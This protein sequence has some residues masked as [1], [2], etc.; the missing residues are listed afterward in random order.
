MIGRNSDGE[1]TFNVDDR[2]EMVSALKEI[3]ATTAVGRNYKKNYYTKE[4]GDADHEKLVKAATL[5]AGSENISQSHLVRALT[6]LLDSGEIQPKDF[7]QAAPLEEPQEDTRPRDKNGKLL[8][9]SQLRYREYRQFAETAS[10]D[11]INKRKRTDPGF[12][13]YV[14]KAY[15]AEVK[16]PIGDGVVPEGQSKLPRHDVSQTLVDFARKYNAEPITNLRPKGGFV[17]LAGE[18]IRWSDF[19]SLLTKATEAHLI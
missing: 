19:Q 8:N 5:V 18:Q 14:R 3:F 13:S 15:E 10:M 9:E 6:L 17:T 11:A 7:T 2:D 16:Q 12:A 1:I 4:T